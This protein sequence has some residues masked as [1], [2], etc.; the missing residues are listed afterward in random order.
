MD[1]TT[2]PKRSTL[3]ERLGVGTVRSRI[4]V[5]IILITS[6]SMLA[7][8]AILSYIQYDNVVDETYARLEHS[9]NELRR[10][11]E[12]VVNEET[13][14]PSP[15]SAE[16]FI[17]AFL[18]QQY[19]AANE[20]L[21]GF[22]S[23]SLT[24]YQGGSGYPIQDN[25]ELVAYISPLTASATTTWTT[26]ETE[27]GKFVILIVPVL[28]GESEPGA[29]AF[30]HHLTAE[31][32]PVW[33]FMRAF[34]IVSF[35]TVVLAAVAASLSTGRVMKPLADLRQLSTEIS[36]HNLDGRLPDDQPTEDLKDLATAFN[37]MVDRMQQAFTSQYQ[38]LDDAGHELRTPVT[39]VAGHL[40]VMDPHDP[41]DVKESRELALG[42]LDRMKRLTNDLVLLAKTER[43]DFLRF[44]PTDIGD[45][46]RE[47]VIH[48]EQ[49]GDRNWVLG[50][51]AHVVVR[52]DE[53]RILQ[54]WLQLAANAV[55]FSP[56]NSTVTISS[57]VETSPAGRELW[58][59]VKDEGV[60]ISREDQKRIFD[61]F[62]RVDHAKEGA[63]LGLSIVS[64]IAR[65]HNGRVAVES[66]LGKGSTFSV[67]LPLPDETGT[68][69]SAAEAD[70]A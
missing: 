22:V 25:P 17:F 12:R 45:L 1:K 66:V 62:G 64:G 13:A 8:G 58:L 55:K 6:L 51:V 15:E 56:E 65:A 19:P 32:V 38:L 29:I 7:V 57:H 31:L 16:D 33:S 4:T 68:E 61:R 28:V 39:I 69:D 27:D 50:E 23:G 41:D 53:Q 46:T 47:T 26:A 35:I 2:A 70:I 37:S 60:G 10:F 63:G 5:L 43:P 18:S 44:G 3:R 14:F 40:E 9:E 42:E 34:A 48:S 52:A 67:I 54:A 24:H 49:L 21:A 36:E 30:V 20:G 59:S 11:A